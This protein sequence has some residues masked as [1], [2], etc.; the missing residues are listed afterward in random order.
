MRAFGWC[1]CLIAA[2]AVL[3]T[4]AEGAG[5]QVSQVGLEVAANFVGLDGVVRPGT[6]TPIRLSLE[7]RSS[8]T[9]PVVC[10][11]VLNDYDG[12]RVVAQR[13]V[14]LNPQR[15][16][17][18]WLYGV[19][20]V[21]WRVT[22]PWTLRV[23]D[24]ASNDLLATG[25][26]LPRQTIH[27][28]VVT[29]GVFGSAALGLNP[30]TEQY[31]QHEK[32]HLIRGLDLATLPDRWYGLSLFHAMIWTRG[33]GDPD[34]PAIT[35]DMQ[36]AVRE[37]VQRGGH[38]V[39]VLPAINQPWTSSALADLLP[40]N[41]QQMSRVEDYAP[42]WLG[43]RK[44]AQRIKIEMTVFSV[45][46]G[47]GVA[48]LSRD[49]QDRP[50]VVAARYGFG[51][52][53]LIG[54]D[55][56]DPRLVR[57]G[58][59]NGGYRIW[60]TVFNWQSPIFSRAFIDGEVK[61][62]KMSE[63]R[64]RRPLELGGIVLPQIAMRGTS[65]PALLLAIVVFLLYWAVAGPIGFAVL[66]HKGLVHHS[67]LAF[68]VIVMVF[69][70][71]AWAGAWMMQPK[72]AMIQHFSVLDADGHSGLVHTHSWLSI[73]VTKFGRA[74]VAIDPNQ[75]RNRNTLA[76]P[77][78]VKQIGDSG[79]L[80]PQAYAI[81]AAAPN[82]ADVPVRATAKQFEIDYLGR[83]DGEQPGLAKPWI[84]PQ[85]QIRIE[86]FWPS[87]TLSHGLPG[88]L[89]NVLIVYCTG[90]PKEQWVWRHGAWSADQ[91]LRLQPPHEYGKTAD[92][93]V[94]PRPP[95][96]KKRQ[97]EMEGFLGRLI[98][99]K[100]GL[101]H[102]G[103]DD[104]LAVRSSGDDTVRMIELLSFYDS[105]PPPNFRSVDVINP[106]VAYQR[107]Q[108]RNFDLTRLVAG[109][110]LILIG[111]LDDSPLPAPVTV[112]GETLNSTGWTVVRWIYDL[113]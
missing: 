9:R 113:E 47:D 60:N 86:N 82:T 101:R 62:Q 14:T 72:R 56:V 87:G 64:D 45:G 2:V 36:Q 108:G 11:W 20:P 6:W 16:Q 69:S 94:I 93:L 10:R 97:W 42:G 39:I 55:L 66:R 70:G 13:R 109:R 54:T 63:P 29:L 33:G 7:N 75:P 17:H 59:P 65:A 51:R 26:V 19:P 74:E 43:R 103:I 8:E 22:V 40:V 68:V 77:G 23:V 79:F 3:G 46:S 112:D 95:Y 110:R 96:P 1:W 89:K 34:D 88:D 67:W 98:D 12:D 28:S 73:L 111:H 4:V 83:L 35:A 71:V 57:E 48:V 107:S 84:M 105:L 50:L 102:L 25:R 44:S 80:D 18:V 37:W 38:L 106:T 53:T 91:L 104:P 99:T 21:N 27:P 76:S 92:R 49:S 52:V 81:D 85:G 5:A 61:W 78:L 90:D 15:T 41:E 32:L 24:E 58:L 31:T 100:T 30:Y